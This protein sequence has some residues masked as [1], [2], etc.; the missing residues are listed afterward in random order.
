MLKNVSKPLQEIKNVVNE[1]KY[2]EVNLIKEIIKN[3][4]I[5]DLK[6]V[7]VSKS[8]EHISSELSKL[9]TIVDIP[10]NHSSMEKLYIGMIDQCF[11]LLVTHSMSDSATKK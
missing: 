10:E 9:I 7:S 3:N 5:E 11:L 2:Y 6:N 8:H 4:K 1:F